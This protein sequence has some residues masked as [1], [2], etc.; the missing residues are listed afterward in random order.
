[1]IGRA[2]FGLWT[3]IFAF[4]FVGRIEIQLVKSIYRRPKTKDRRPK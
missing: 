1:L 2:V 4:C 3:L